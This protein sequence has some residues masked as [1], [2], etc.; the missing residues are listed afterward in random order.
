[1]NKLIL[2]LMVP[3][4]SACTDKNIDNSLYQDSDA[5]AYLYGVQ[6]TIKI[7]ELRKGQSKDQVTNILE[8]QGWIVKAEKNL[9]VQ[10][11]GSLNNIIIASKD[12]KN[13]EKKCHAVYLELSKDTGLQAINPI[14]C[15]ILYKM[16]QE[17]N[18]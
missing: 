15:M 6:N 14:D 18:N 13:S 1:M 11:S 5:V 9:Q 17:F 7:S 2:I 8:K 4:I 12:E 10:K 16:A 3:I